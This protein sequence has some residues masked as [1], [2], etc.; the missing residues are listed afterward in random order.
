MSPSIQNSSHPALS[1][2]DGL[3]AG[4]SDIILLVGRILIGWIFVRS[5][6]GKIFDVPSY[7][8]TF[9]PRGLPTFLAYIAVPAEFFGGL[10][11][12]FGF[13][14]RYAVL[15][16]VVFMLVATFSSHRYWDFADV[17]VRRA[18]DSNFYKNM[19]ILGGIFFL[20][21]CGAGRLSIDAWLR[22]QR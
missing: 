11:L 14:T 12:M 3:A 4:T 1:G 9:P 18:Q 21:A 10:A 13:A 16:M 5:G 20:F 2:V 8:S 7:A 15:V 17:A 19:A 6:Y 22:K